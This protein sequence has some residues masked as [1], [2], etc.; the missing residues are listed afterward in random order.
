MACDEGRQAFTPPRGPFSLN[1][2][3]A[4]VP[5]GSAARLAAARVLV[6]LQLLGGQQRVELAQ[7]AVQ[8]VE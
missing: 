7:S 4:P 5:V 8:A 3:V 6:L 2:L 1:P